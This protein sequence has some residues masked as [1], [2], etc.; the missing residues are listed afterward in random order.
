MKD[1]RTHL[2]Y[3][4]E[5]VVDLESDLVLAAEIYPADRADTDTLVDSVM[6]AKVNVN[7]A[8][9]RA[10]W[11]GCEIEEVAADKG[12]HAAATLEL[13]DALEPADVHPGA[14]AEARVAL[15]GQA[16]GLSDGGASTTG[17]GLAPREEPQTS[18][19]AE[20]AGGTL[21]RPHLRQRGCPTELAPRPRGRDEALPDRGRR[22]Q[23]GPGPAEALR[24]RQA[25]GLAR[26]FRALF[27]L[28][29]IA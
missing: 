1:G 17:V 5:H 16:R 7:A 18:T 29:Q 13:A 28:V 15:D 22:A 19:A 11:A 14:E 4:A 23:P 3:K 24:D 25:E 20:R 10:G 8:N 6:Q 9:E 27:A 12:Y 2:A 21:V 26:G